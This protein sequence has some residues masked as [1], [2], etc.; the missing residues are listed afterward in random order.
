M[1]WIAELTGRLG[2]GQVTVNET[3]REHHSHDESYH[4]PVLPDVVVFAEKTADVVQVLEFACEHCIPV[5]PF[6]AGTALEG[7]TVPVKRG[8]SLDLT[9]MNAILEIRPD[10]FL[11]HVEP[12]VTRTQLNEALKPYGLFFPVD[13]GAD[14]TLGG[15][16]ATSASGTTTVHY[17][18]MRDNVRKMAVVLADGRVIETGS[19]AAKSSSG[20]NLNHLFIGSEGTLGV[21]T[22][23]WLKLYGLPQKTISARAEF[24]SVSHCV[25]A[26]TA[27]MGAGIPVVRL[28]LV[29][30][31]MLEAINAYNHTDYRVTPTL[32]LEFH[33]NEGGVDTDVAL[34]QE[35]LQDEGCLDIQ[36]EQDTE[37]QNRLW[38]ARHSA[39]TAFKH[40]RPGFGHMTT[41]VC[42]PLSAL[43]PTVEFAEQALVK[44]GIDGGIVG[45]VGDG[46]FHVSMAVK[47]ADE[48][49]MER[50]EA[51]NS[52]LVH[53]ALAAGGTCTG[54]HGVG[55]GKRQYQAEEHGTALAVMRTLKQVLDAGGIMNPGKLID[56][57]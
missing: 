55:L 46:N 19:L 23:L 33:G 29:S 38:H 34:A 37:G 42:V 9:K 54:E 48:E 13:P 2:S 17:G 56:L 57:N 31:V 3:V 20:Y 45:H 35:L 53:R 51:F 44:Y 5:V 52:A 22:D 28:E 4:T 43:A 39:A 32:F 12:G 18:A 47:P 27:L 14:A 40:M 6:G 1:D 7:H 11:A 25:R 36:F 8:I 50:A 24:P 16:A 49:L 30:P 21:I 10:D 15:M 41:D 26:S